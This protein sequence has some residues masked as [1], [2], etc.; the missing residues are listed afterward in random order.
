[1]RSCL[2]SLVIYALWGMLDYQSSYRR[3]VVLFQILSQILGQ[4]TLRWYNLTLISLKFKR[5]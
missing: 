1:M 4:T 5:V 2:G 3:D